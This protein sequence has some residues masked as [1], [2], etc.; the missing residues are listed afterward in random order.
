MCGELLHAHKVK[1]A[2]EVAVSKI[3]SYKLFSSAM[4][5]Q[6]GTG[7]TLTDSINRFAVF[8]VTLD[9]QVQW[10]KAVEEPLL[11]YAV[12]GLGVGSYVTEQALLCL[13]GLSI[14]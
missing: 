2:A 9:P 1:Y 4:L 13:T 10:E 12:Q 11:V 8:A 3:R 5:V 7:K 6:Q 14:D